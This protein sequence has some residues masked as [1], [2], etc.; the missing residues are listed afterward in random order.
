MTVMRKHQRYF[1]VYSEDGALLPRFVSIANGPVDVDLVAAGSSQLCTALTG[2]W[3]SWDIPSC[4]TDLNTTRWDPHRRRS[5]QYPQGSA[6]VGDVC[7][8]CLQEED[9]RDHL[10][11][12]LL[13]T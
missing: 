2:V 12:R 7:T 5:D 1:P 9:G 3:T 4:S 11:Y 6:C 13:A 10:R 8:D